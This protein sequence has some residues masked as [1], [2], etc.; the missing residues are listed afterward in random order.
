MIR[1][2]ARLIDLALAVKSAP[3]DDKVWRQF[4]T[5]SRELS[6]VLA[7]VVADATLFDGQAVEHQPEDV[8]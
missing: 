2:A 5:A 3:G 7:R 4:T 8:P 6:E 1:K